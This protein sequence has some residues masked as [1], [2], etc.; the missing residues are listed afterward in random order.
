MARNKIVCT[1]LM[2]KH[3]ITIFYPVWGYTFPEIPWHHSR[4]SKRH[5]VRWDSIH[6]T[7]AFC[8]AATFL[9]STQG[10]L[11]WGDRI[12]ELSREVGIQSC[13]VPKQVYKKDWLLKHMNP[14]VPLLSHLP[15]WMPCKKVCHD[16]WERPS[17]FAC[18][19]KLHASQCE[20]QQC[21]LVTGDASVSKL[22][23]PYQTWIW[24]PSACNL[25][26]YLLH[27]RHVLPLHKRDPLGCNSSLYKPDE[28]NTDGCIVV[29]RCRWYCLLNHQGSDISF[30]GDL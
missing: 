18:G 24:T 26:G 20:C 6:K 2:T 22:H 15:Q 23:T 29:G 8:L 11:K 10:Q 13:K 17:Q 14:S 27:G 7:F 19:T 30:L 28:S 21:G 25:G 3:M 16:Q 12:Q 4:R 1:K 5:R 9:H